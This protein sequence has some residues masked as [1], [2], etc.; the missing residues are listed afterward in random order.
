MT[1]DA[2]EMKPIGQLGLQACVFSP[3]LGLRQTGADD[4]GQLGQLEG[5]VQEVVSAFLH[6]RDRLGHATKTAYDNRDD[7]WIAVEREAQHRH[8]VTAVGQTQVDDNRVEGEAPKTG[9]CGFGVG[10][11]GD[12]KTV[13]LQRFGQQLPQVA[14]VLDDDHRGTSRFAHRGSGTQAATRA[15]AFPM[16]GWYAKQVSCR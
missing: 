8:S 2:F 13:S 10:C 16:S 6:G 12:R 11:L 4:V 15:L 1:N 5:L 3:P 14:V 7:L 9:H